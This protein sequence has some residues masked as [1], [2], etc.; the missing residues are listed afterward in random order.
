VTGSD[1]GNRLSDQAWADRATER[2]RAFGT[3]AQWLRVRHE[4]AF[5]D[6]MEEGFFGGLDA[7]T[8]ARVDD[9][10]EPIRDRIR[11]NS[12]EWLVADGELRVGHGR[13]ARTVAAAVVALGPDGAPLTP[14]QRDFVS[15]LA[16]RRLDVYRVEGI[17]PPDRVIVRDL[18]APQEPLRHVDD[19]DVV[20]SEIEAGD[21][22]GARLLPV[23]DIRW[24]F[25]PALY[26]LSA[27]ARDLLL[28]DIVRQA[29]RAGQAVIT[30][31][32]IDTLLP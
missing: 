29:D 12:C 30:A 4:R 20:T 7:A 5:L 27:E 2:I 32:L 28:P 14:D 24:E 19:R 26:P 22:I 8:R 6:A 18:L 16:R 3:A 31:W 23:D 13:T 9:A 15:A 25:S 21:V 11:F 17:A 1:P 10:P